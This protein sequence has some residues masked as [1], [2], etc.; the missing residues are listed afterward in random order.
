MQQK[1]KINFNQERDFGQLF[2]DTLLFVKQNFKPFFGSIILIAGPL[3]LVMGLAY[4][5]VQTSILSMTA[6]TVNPSNPFA[7]FNGDYFMGM[8]VIFISATLAFI[9]VGAVSFHF[10]CLYNEKPIEEKIT[11]SEV[12][13]RLTTNIGRLIVSS[14]V[15]L[16]TMIGIGIVAILIFIG[17]GS[18]LGV[19]G[20]VI[21][22]LAA[23][24]GAIILGPVIHYYITASFYVVVRDNLFIYSAMGKV[25]KYLSGSFWWTWLIMVVL[26][27]SLSIVQ[28]LF[29]LPAS[30][31]TMG[32]MFTRMSAP[33]ATEEGSSILLMVFYTI[34]MFLTY[35]S[36]SI[37]HVACAFN[38]LSHEEK[39]EGKGMIAQIESI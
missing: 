8:A 28:M 10:M 29:S 31:L 1:V 36:Y 38:F 16:L 27:I 9:L 12:S 26:L 5:Y 11:I 21:I 3:I 32:K 13:K 37:S 7:M 25:K 18:G 20:A 15:F 19:G 2:S 24:F 39:H 33:G 6:R 23:F 4:A 22:G 14:I 35:C 34:S 17:L 30:I